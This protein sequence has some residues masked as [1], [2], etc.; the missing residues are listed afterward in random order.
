M[1]AT[2]TP[3]SGQARDRVRL[4]IPDKD[5]TGLTPSGGV[6]TLTTY[7]Y[8]DAEL[9]DFLATED[10][11]PKRAAALALES[12]VQAADGKVSG[13]GYTIETNALKRAAALRQQADEDDYAAGAA[14]DIAEQV[15]N[16][17][18]ARERLLKQAQRGAI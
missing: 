16:A 13:L 8:L 2:Y 7:A 17:F 9:D 11:N 15:P 1:S 6:Y 12:S 18:A 14:F 3:G 10:N 5:V 4:L